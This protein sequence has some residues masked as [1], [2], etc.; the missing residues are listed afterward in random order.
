MKTLGRIAII[1]LAALV[2]AGATLALSQS[3]LTS[4]LLG[5]A[6][7]GRFE[8]GRGEHQMPAGQPTSNFERHGRDEGM[9]GIS[10]FALG[11]II[12]DVVIMGGIAALV[13]AATLLLR[14]GKR[15]KR[16]PPTPSA[17]PGDAQHG[18]NL[19]ADIN[20]A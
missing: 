6:G 8:G 5:Q 14:A 16:A 7:R 9:G 12:K 15:S 4:S 17:G 1:L 19:P 11:P 2:V 13:I 18:L 20:R 10:L 3:T